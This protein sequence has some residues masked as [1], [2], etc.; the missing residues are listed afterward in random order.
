[1][2]LLISCALLLASIGYVTIAFTVWRADVTSP[3]RIKYAFTGCLLSLWSLCFCIMTVAEVEKVRFAFWAIGL[4]MS[5]LFYPSWMGFFTALMQHKS[6][7]TNYL[8][9]M[10]YIG[11]FSVSFM[12]IT[13]GDVSFMRTQAGW[14]FIY[15]VSAPFIALITYLSISGTI[16]IFYAVKRYK[17]VK[18]KRQ[19][20]E[21]LIFV[22]VLIASTPFT[23][24]F[25]YFVPIFFGESTFPIS[26]IWVFFASLPLRHTMSSHWVF[27]ITANN[28]SEFL[29][30]SLSFPVLLTNNENIVQLANSVALQ[31]WSEPL[32]GEHIQSLIHLDGE[33][34]PSSL[35]NSEF[36]G[37]QVTHVN[38]DLGASFDM[39]QRIKYDEFGD[40]VSKTVVFNDVTKLQNALSLA[41]SASIAKSEFLS[42][43]S[44]ELRTPMNAIIGMTRI[45]KESMDIEEIKYCLDRVDGA[46]GHLLAL[47]NDILDMSKIEANKFELFDAPFNFDDMLETIHNIISD[48]AQEKNLELT[49]RRDSALPNRFIGDRLRLVQIITNLL[50][51]A[52]KFTPLGGK[53]TLSVDLLE[54]LPED[55]VSVYIEVA[56]SGIG[57]SEE[58]QKKLFKPFEQAEKS[59][60]STYGGTG[61]GLSIFKRIVELMGGSVG[62]SSEEGKGS[63]FYCNVKLK[64]NTAPEDVDYDNLLEGKH[65]TFSRCRMLLAEDIEINREIMLA[66]LKDLNMQID[67]AVD[68]KQAFDM[69]SSSEG[70]YDIILMDVQMPIMGGLQATREIRNSNITNAKS[71]P[72]IAITANAFAEDIEICLKAG[73]ND[74]IS[75]PVDADEMLRKINH[76]L[77]GKED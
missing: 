73:M 53:V 29:F 20:R 38:R 49:F 14:Q 19:I 66:L 40:V 4:C 39:L 58:G 16:L 30:S 37:V 24:M 51:N 31:T 21:S 50:S 75:K 35:F 45:G 9:A 33:Q 47:I 2:N 46:S 72:I 63:I 3:L 28:V 41:E 43:I 64:L 5:T 70:S 15:K 10:M 36:T 18:L 52:V 26:S 25:D 55:M 74:H 13:S 68:G 76:Y 6:K 56:D 22:V 67:C 54:Y 7:F 77:L 8:I 32:M 44:H 57:I 60:S 65:S 23:A 17:S 71:V 27:N 1:M 11:A 69:F 34:P 48:R 42:R 61:L 62:V 12:C 59:T